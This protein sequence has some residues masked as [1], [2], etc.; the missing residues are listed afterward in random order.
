[1]NTPAPILATNEVVD[2]INARCLYSIR[3]IDRVLG[4]EL[5]LSCYVNSIISLMRRDSDFDIVIDHHLVRGQCNSFFCT[6][7]FRT[8]T[9]NIPASECLACLNKFAALSYT[10]SSQTI[11]ITEID[12]DYDVIN[13]SV[14]I[15]ALRD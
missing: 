14:M 8:L 10:L 13:N 3:V 15:D 1:M 11:N 7:C 5:C 2:N 12:F 6:K 4:L 9:L